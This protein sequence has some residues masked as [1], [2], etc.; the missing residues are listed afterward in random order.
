METLDK[1][2]LVTATGGNHC[3]PR[4]HSPPFVPYPYPYAAAPRWAYAG[5]FP[6]Y[7]Y[8]YA[9]PPPRWAA[10]PGPWWASYRR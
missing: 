5:G 4:G 3:A 6:P 1:T 7:A 8:N 9:P 2:T 10:A